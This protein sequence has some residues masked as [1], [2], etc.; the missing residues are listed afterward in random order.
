MDKLLIFDDVSC[1]DYGVDTLKNISLDIERGENVIIFGPEN[2]GQQ[3]LC[4]LIA[5]SAEILEG[6]IYYNDKSIKNLNFLDKIKYKKEIGYL[7]RVAGLF[8]NMTVEEN[9]SLPLQYHSHMTALEIKQYVEELMSELS[10]TTCKDKRPLDLSRAE[11]L[12][13]AYARATVFDPDLVMIEHAFDGQSHL[14][15]LSFFDVLSKRVERKEKA[16]IF[17]TF[18]PQS[19]LSIAHKLIMFY[20]NRIVFTGT[21]DEYLNTENPYVVQYRIM[22]KSGPMILT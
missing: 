1:K 19:F 5:G 8:S 21:P 3:L 18:N 17:V 4:P 9:I 10:L 20:G 22:S 11:V 6:D 14:H 12:K 16:I 15:L 13:T 2:S 7:S